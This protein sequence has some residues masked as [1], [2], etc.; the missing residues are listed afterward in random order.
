MN[1]RLTTEEIAGIK[2]A[3]VEV[4]GDAATVR[5]FGSRVDDAKRGGDIDL[6]VEVPEGRDTFRDELVL[7]GALEDRLGERM[8]TILL[9]Q[10]KLKRSPIVAIAYRDGV[11]M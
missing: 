11:V 2:A 6:L 3:V 5:L 4:F 7:A 10:P 9:Q 8:I 1:V